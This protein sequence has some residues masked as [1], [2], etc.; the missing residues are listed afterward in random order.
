MVI[1]YEDKYSELMSDALQELRATTDVSQLV[2]GAKARAL[3][4]IVNRE[5]GAVYRIFSSEGAK[6]RVTISNQAIR[7]KN[8]MLM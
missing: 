8:S 5:L 2:P 4:E 3:L 6:Q 1:F 7:S